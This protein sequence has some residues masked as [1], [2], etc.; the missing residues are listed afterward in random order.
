MLG[1]TVPKR[2]V[3]GFNFGAISRVEQTRENQLLFGII[4]SGGVGIIFPKI[5][6]NAKSNVGVGTVRP[7]ARPVGLQ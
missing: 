4:F 6:P 3:L 2:D 7:R 1:P 5:I